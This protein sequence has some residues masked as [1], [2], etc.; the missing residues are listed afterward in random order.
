MKRI[1]AFLTLKCSKISVDDVIASKWQMTRVINEGYI[2]FRIIYKY[3]DPLCAGR[4]ILPPF[5][6]GNPGH[7]TFFCLPRSFITLFLPCPALINH[8]FNSFIFQCAAL[9]L[10]Y[11]S[12]PALF[13]HT[14]FTSDPG[15]AR[16]GWG[17]NNFTGALWL[18]EIL[19]T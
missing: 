15:A 5:P 1:K 11:F 8:L 2:L 12:V 14:N 3:Q 4:I 9:S 18:E 10:L 19:I 13:Y 6:T 7:I 17:Q 16:R